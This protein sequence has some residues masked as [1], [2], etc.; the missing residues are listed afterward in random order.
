MTGIDPL[1]GPSIYIEKYEDTEHTSTPR[2]GTRTHDPITRRT[3][4]A[5]CDLYT[6][7]FKIAVSF[8]CVTL[9]RYFLSKVDDS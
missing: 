7:P 8:L 4:R 2:D 9:R 6:L 3:L 1:Q 5:P